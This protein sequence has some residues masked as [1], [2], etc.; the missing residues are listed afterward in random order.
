LPG[1]QRVQIGRRKNPG[2]V[3]AE[4]P[5]GE[6]K[7][8]REGG[9]KGIASTV[10]WGGERKGAFTKQK[11]GDQTSFFKFRHGKPRDN[12]YRKKTTHVGGPKAGDTKEL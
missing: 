8:M 10:N 9:R 6:K 11:W 12:R 4:A 7:E 3:G 5:G 1:D 2:K